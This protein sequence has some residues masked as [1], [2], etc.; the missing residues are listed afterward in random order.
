MISLSLT[1]SKFCKSTESIKSCDFYELSNSDSMLRTTAQII[2]FM[3][4]CICCYAFNDTAIMIT[5]KDYEDLKD[6]NILRL[7]S[8][9]IISELN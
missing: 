3:L 6:I 5:A 8:F 9:S 4:C 2:S 7:K 1:S